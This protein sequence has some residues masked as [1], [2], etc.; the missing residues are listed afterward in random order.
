MP[1]KLV[2]LF[3]ESDLF[4]GQRLSLD[5]RESH[6]LVNVLRL[7]PGDAFLIFNGRDGEWIA[8]VAQTT[9]KQT[10]VNVKEL[11]RSQKDD[12]PVALLFS[13]LKAGPLGFLMEKA[14][15]L[16]VTDFYPLWTTRTQGRD[17][18]HERYLSIIREASEQ[19]ERMCVPSLHK[20]LF[21]D[22]L[23]TQWDREKELLICDERPGG[24]NLFD[25]LQG[26]NVMNSVV[27]GP[28]GGFSP[29]EFEFLDRLPNAIFVSLGQNVLRAETAAL[30]ALSLLHSKISW[31]QGLS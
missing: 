31:M 3:V 23:L 14:T 13:P 4:H 19:S 2:R 6:Y 24:Q 12:F 10:N 21:L 25:L 11:V 5:L 29:E 30:S 7:T 28:E 15:E 26:E 1:R 18:R 27:I 20:P 22:K 17:F 9:K 16:G 8:E